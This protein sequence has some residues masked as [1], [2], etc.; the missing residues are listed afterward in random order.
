MIIFRFFLV[1][2]LLIMVLVSQLRGGTWTFNEFIYKP[3]VGARGANE[4]SSYD[5][6]M[7]RIDARLGKEI[8]VGDPKY[9]TTLQEAVTAIGA[10]SVVLRVSHGTYNIA[11]NLTIP[12]NITLKPERGAV[13]TVATGKTLTI[14]GGFDG[15]LYQVFSCAGTGKVVFGDGAVKEVYPE[16]WGGGPGIAA[17][18]NATALNAAFA[19]HEKVRLQK[20]TY[21]VAGALSKTG[22]LFL[23][24]AGMDVTTISG[25]DTGTLLTLTSATTIYGSAIRNLTVQSSGNTTDLININNIWKADLGNLKLSGGANQIVLSGTSFE[26]DIRNSRFSGFT[27]F[28]VDVASAANGAVIDNCDFAE[29]T[30]G[31]AI[32]TAAHKVNITKSWFEA[33]SPNYAANHILINGGSATISGCSIGTTRAGGGAQISITD[34]SAQVINNSRIAS[35]QPDYPMISVTAPAMSGSYPNYTKIAGNVLLDPQGWFIEASG[36]GIIEIVD[37]DFYALQGN[38]TTYDAFIRGSNTDV[39]VRGNRGHMNSATTTKWLSEL[40]GGVFS[41]N[42]VYRMCGCIGRAEVANGNVISATSNL[43]GTGLVAEIAEGNYVV[44]AATGMDVNKIGAGNYIS[45]TSSNGIRT[46]AVTAAGSGYTALDLV[47]VTTGGGNAKIRVLTVG[48]SG[49]ILTLR[50]VN[51]GSGYSTGA[52]QAT[53]GGSGTGFTVNVI[54]LT[55][56]LLNSGGTAMV[57]GNNGH[58]TENNGMATVPDGATSV[59]VSHGLSAAPDAADIQVTPTNNLG[60][61]AKFWISN[62]GATDFDINVN[63][64][65]GASTATFVWSAFKR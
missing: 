58:V 35:S 22:R 63:A 30:G 24:G 61:A 37:N 36:A 19:A 14:N 43:L 49:E 46:A 4:K 32:R 51:A 5:S 18:T 64:D 38:M 10:N 21:S 52:G 8:W 6:G 55:T 34:G 16:W 54:G 25:D 41:G 2:V 40:T 56:T 50:V 59:T 28:G 13:F 57:K 7:D 9:G 3:E 48:A 15:G 65:P 47:T 31:T 23:E 20:G 44:N 45:G 53:S 39:T 17:A 12:A 27:G 42:K 62:V 33:A 29:K 11:D 60:N 1:I 26:P